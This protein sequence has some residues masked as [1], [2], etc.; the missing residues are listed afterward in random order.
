MVRFD[1]DDGRLVDMEK[2]ALNNYFHP[3]MKGRT[4]IKWTLPAVFKAI[5]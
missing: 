4:S 3:K 2:I 5:N 1:K